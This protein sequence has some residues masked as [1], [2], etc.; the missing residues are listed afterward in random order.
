MSNGGEGDTRPSKNLST[1]KNQRRAEARDK[2]R[3]LREQHKKKERRSKYLLQG[4]IIVGALAIIAVVTVII[5][6]SIRPP[7]PGPLNMLSDGIVIGTGF[8]AQT[9]AALEA[10]EEPVKSTPA[11]GSTAIPIQIWLDYQCPICAD[12]EKANAEQISTLVSQGIATLEIHPVA[13]LDRVSQG[14]RY[15]SRAANAAACVANYSPNTFFDFS[16]LM[17]EEQPAEN[18]EGLTDEQLISITEDAGVERAGT[19][20]DC[21]TD[22]RFESWVADATERATSDEALANPTSGQFGTPTVFVGGARYPGAPD[23]ATAF[24]QFVAAADGAAFE[25]SA[26]SPSPSPSP[27]G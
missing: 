10:G 13:I 19:I 2:A 4:G 16:A 21:I 5:T 15:S 26:A 8:Q 24:A 17:F 1:T 27:A 18:S 3:A 14:T 20:A 7:A 12:F 25:E 22:E 9:T 23:D 6:S 11:E